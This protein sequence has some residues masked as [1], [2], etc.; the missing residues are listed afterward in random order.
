VLARLLAGGEGGEEEGKMVVEHVLESYGERQDLAIEWIHQLYIAEVRREGGGAGKKGGKGKE[1]VLGWEWVLN[2]LLDGLV[3]AA[4][5]KAAKKESGAAEVGVEQQ[6]YLTRLIAETPCVGE[7]VIERV[8]G[9][10]EGDDKAVRGLGLACLRAVV[11]NHD[12]WKRG[13]LEKLLGY[14]SSVDETLR[15]PAIRLVCGKQFEALKV[16]KEIEEEAVANLRRACRLDEKESMQVEG[17]APAGLDRP[18]IH[19]FLSLCAQKP[20]LL[21]KLLEAYLE[22]SAPIRTGIHA[23]ISDMI[24]AIGPTS[25]ELQEMMEECPAGSEVLILAFV[26][27][28]TEGGAAHPQLVAT[29]QVTHTYP[30]PLAP[31][32]FSPW[33]LRKKLPLR[34]MFPPRLLPPTLT[35]L[36]VISKVQ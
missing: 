34:G 21:S 31:M 32:E 8:T 33:A 4:R 9:M 1:A 7:A 23:T 10:C 22:S 5:A 25:K 16:S 13:C 2:T 15:A 20:R 11:Y 29:I 35:R 18:K 28:L 26:A 6:R 12:R 3:D 19:L 17:E 30:T 27:T 24:R 14:T 36:C